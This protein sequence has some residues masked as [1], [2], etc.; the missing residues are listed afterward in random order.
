MA[1]HFCLMGAILYIYSARS[2]IPFLLFSR[3]N[4]DRFTEQRR[5]DMLTLP[6]KPDLTNFAATAAA[7]MGLKAAPHMSAPVKELTEALQKNAGGII[8]KAL[9]FHA[10]AV[11]AYVIEKYPELFSRVRKATQLEIP[12]LSVMPSIT[13]VCFAAMFSGAY[14]HNNGVPEYCPPILRDDLVQPAITCSTLIDLL[15]ASGL[16]TAV[17][18]CSNGCIASM[19]YGRGA[20]LYIIPDDDDEAMYQKAA[21]LIAEEDY[22]ALF[23]Y[24]LSYDY[25]MH[26]YGPEGEKALEALSKITQRFGVL[27]DAIR[28]A[29]KDKRVLTVFNSDHGSHATPQGGAHGEDIPEDMEMRWFFGAF[30]AGE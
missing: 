24:Q 23:L 7:A 19:L 15:T 26:A 2:S 1:V 4:A 30:P 9:F 11:P 10:D 6:E 21:A 5:M 27:S 13:P 28:K 14:P 29:W 25:A 8:E 20:D 18:T 22:D 3:Y 12:V 17:V 16:R